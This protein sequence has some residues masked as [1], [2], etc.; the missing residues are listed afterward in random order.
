MIQIIFHTCWIFRWS[1]IPTIQGSDFTL[2]ST[3]PDTTQLASPATVNMNIRRYSMLILFPSLHWKCRSVIV[4]VHPNSENIL[5]Q[6]GWWWITI[7]DQDHSLKKNP[8]KSCH[9][10]IPTM[11]IS[12]PPNSFQRVSRTTMPAALVLLRLY[13]ET[14]LVP[15][16]KKKTILRCMSRLCSPRECRVAL[17]GSFEGSQICTTEFI[18]VHK[19]TWSQWNCTKQGNK[20]LLDS[21]STWLHDAW[22]PM[23][24]LD[25]L[26]NGCS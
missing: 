26:P 20:E 10:H 14:S 24:L 21:H 15:K 18:R 8:L 12:N 23:H 25:L 17:V 7:T 22:R 4:R 3:R 5:K 1:M 9:G 13:T 19:M 2:H 11:L 6:V 16:K